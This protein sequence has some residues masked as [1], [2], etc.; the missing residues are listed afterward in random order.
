[1]HVSFRELT[2]ISVLDFISPRIQKGCTEFRMKVKF[3]MRCPLE[4]S[5]WQQG[6]FCCEPACPEYSTKIEMGNKF[7][8]RKERR[9][10]KMTKMTK[11]KWYIHTHASL[12]T[13]W[14]LFVDRV[15]LILD[16][17]VF[18]PDLYD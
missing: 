10:L 18:F 11:R 15:T 2:L 17:D 16:S 13:T 6:N 8:S 12:N 4:D 1:M 7:I 3:D 9:A 5:E 14:L